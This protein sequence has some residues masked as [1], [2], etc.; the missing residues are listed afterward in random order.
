MDAGVNDPYKLQRFLDAQDGAFETALDE[1]RAGLKVSHWMWFIFPQ[2]AGLGRTATAQFYAIASIDEARA[3][4]EHP[5]L[6]PRLRQC[7][8]ALLQWPDRRSAEQILGAVDALKLRSSLTLFDRVEPSGPFA[9]GLSAFYE[10]RQDERTLALL[11]A[12][13]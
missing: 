8:D 13:A 10:G 6:G 9:R 12:S 4:L 2:L 5:L 11:N 1:L 3:Y 7:V